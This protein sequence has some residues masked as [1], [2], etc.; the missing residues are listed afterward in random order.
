MPSDRHPSREKLLREIETHQRAI[1][2]HCFDPAADGRFDAEVATR[3]AALVAEVARLPRDQLLALKLLSAAPDKPAAIAGAAAPAGSRHEIEELVAFRRLADAADYGFGIA[4]L[5]GNIVYA[6]AALCRMLGEADSDVALGKNVIDYYPEELRDTVSGHM[7][8]T[9]LEKGHWSGELP[10]LSRDGRTTPTIQNLFVVRGEAEA[11]P[12]LANL[13]IDITQRKRVEDA[14]R[15][16]EERFRGIFEHSTIG[17]YRTTPAGSIVMANP[18]VVRMLGYSTFEELEQ[19]DLETEGYAPQYPRSTFKEMME[20]DGEVRGNE[21]V[22]LRKDGTPLHVRES[23][24]AIRNP[25]GKIL[26]YE[27]TVEDVTE[28]HEAAEALRTSEENFRALAEN[29][30]DGILIATGAGVHV[31]ANARAAEITGYDIEELVGMSYRELTHPDELVKIAETYKRR[32]EGSPVPRNYETRIVAKGDRH[33]PIEVTGAHTTWQGEVADIIMIRDITNRKLAEQALHE[34]QEKYRNLVEEIDEIFYEM[35]G[36]GVVTYVSPAIETVLGYHPSEVAGR[37]VYDF[38]APAEIPLAKEL[39]AEFR[40]DQPELQGEH[41]VRTKSGD[42]RWVRHSSRPILIGDRFVG[43]RGV[44]IDITDLKQAEQALIE[45]QKKY[46]ALVEEIDEVIYEFDERGIVTY[47]SPAIE[48][49]LGYQPSDLIGRTFVDFVPPEDLP[50]AQ[51]RLARVRAGKLPERAEIR[52][53]TKSGEIRWGRHNSRPI[54]RGGKI[55]GMRGL[56]I[57]ITE[58]KR[59][60]EA[61]IE[62]QRKYRSLAEEIDEVIYEFDERG[63]I[64]YVSPV[65]EA[66]F[67]YHPS[68]LVG[69]TFVDLVPPEDRPAARE[70]F[71]RLLAEG[72]PAQAEVRLLT[73]S[74]E[75]RWLRHRSRPITVGD[76]SVGTRGV[77]IDITDLK[78]AHQALEESEVKYATL[79]ER[80]MDG[81]IIIQDEKI[82]FAN[83]AVARGMDYS[84]DELEGKHFLDLVAPESRPMVAERYRRRQNGEDVPAFYILKVQHKDGSTRDVEMAPSVIQYQGRVATMA[85]MR[86]I[87][88]REKAGAELRESEKLCAHL[89]ERAADG[90]MI[91]RDGTIVFANHALNEMLSRRADEVI[92]KPLFDFIAPEGRAEEAARQSRRSAGDMETLTY[93][94]VICRGDGPTV[95]VDIIDHPI[96]CEEGTVTFAFVCKRTGA[97]DGGS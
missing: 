2:E 44:V 18:A 73:K 32:V 78:S 8:P 20:R 63:I 97:R 54:M 92:G 62:S 34:S 37:I 5:R 25:A 86:E 55:L 46:H 7:I 29:A 35:D 16:S 75:I 88:Q 79:I 94:T 36:E 61:L 42:L 80:A 51:E 57:D 70:R 15:E 81:V 40:Q 14:L 82:R 3:Y 87:A 47:V 67:G 17:I 33:V 41:E 22:W 11:P 96:C 45:S 65:V 89:V 19:L 39:A 77:I 84:V 69:R 72:T 28:A 13:I 27:G 59:T 68:E 60:E 74:G 6:N 52:V 50:A 76:R 1:L 53:R 58:S 38:L 30:Q 56:L 21:A 24:Q 23:A 83:H 91:V 66:A 12:Y 43:L 31:Y 93:T 71:S 85:I 95:E 64:T 10:L 9:A 48:A 90:M 26:Y 49:F 4:D